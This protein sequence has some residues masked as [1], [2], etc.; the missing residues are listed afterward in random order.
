MLMVEQRARKLHVKK[1]LALFREADVGH[2]GSIDKDEFR[3][4]LHNDLVKA[5][6]QE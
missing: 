4:V 6:S 5:P 3:N 2:D 1:M